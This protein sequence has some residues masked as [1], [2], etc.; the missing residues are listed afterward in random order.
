MSAAANFE[1]ATRVASPSRTRA[2]E[3]P[4]KPEDEVSRH[5]GKNR[6]KDAVVIAE[7]QKWR[8]FLLSKIRLG[9][10]ILSSSYSSCRRHHA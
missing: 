4:L 3:C 7:Q 2:C 5:S 8:A 1:R 9:Q 6:H 10:S